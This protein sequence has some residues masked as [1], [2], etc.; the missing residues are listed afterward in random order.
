M[1]RVEQAVG[2]V[3]AAREAVLGNNGVTHDFH[4]EI[5]NEAWR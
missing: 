3:G 1:N 2:E 5:P 4:G